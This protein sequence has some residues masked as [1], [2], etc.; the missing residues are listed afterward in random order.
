MNWFKRVLGNRT[1]EH[2]NK[3]SVPRERSRFTVETL[4][5]RQVP[6]VFYYGGS[7]LPHVE[8]Q[9]LFLGKDWSTNQTNSAQVNT[10]NNF[11]ADVTSGPY[12]D[13]LSRAGYGVGRGSASPGAIDN[14]SISANTTISDAAIQARIQQDISSGL[15]QAPDANRLYVVY[16]EPNVAV[17]LGAGEGTTQ[18]GI[19]GYHGAFGGQDASGNRTVIRYAVVAYPGGTV[20]NSSMGTSTVD[21][22][23]A[24]AS[25]ELAEAVTDPDVNYARLGWYDPQ[26][27]EIGDVSESNPNALVRL[28]G[29]LV[30]ETVD[31]ND[32]LLAIAGDTGTTTPA[33]APSPTPIPSSTVATTTSLTAG[34]V[35]YPRY[36]LGVP[37]ATL[38]VTISPA[39]G[40]VTPEGTVALFFRGSVI[41]VASVH[42][43]DGVAI[44]TF[45]VQFFG[46]GSFSFNAQY[47]GSSLFQGS[48][49]NALAVSV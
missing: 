35:R 29:F 39:S 48:V 13:A 36:R 4:E 3:R 44:A 2:A 28:H 49:S 15:L 22:L 25:H 27:G 24:V 26:R 33:P 45:N 40:S 9:A 6:T 5:D 11:M 34:A 18:Q 10:I 38:K 12:M 23:T 17:N 1:R 41:G 47:L 14:V 46:R 16:V 37:T 42:V 32:R 20:R 43:V 8:A 19:L 21:Q 31:K 30:Q 7:V